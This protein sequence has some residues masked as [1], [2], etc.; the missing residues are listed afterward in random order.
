MCD[1]GALPHADELGV[2]TEAEPSYAEDVV[3]GDELADSTADGDDSPANSVPRMRCLGRR[4]PK[5]R[6]LR[7]ET[8]TPLRRFASRV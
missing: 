3:A 7:N 5:T 4:M 2:R 6:R 8:A 1:S